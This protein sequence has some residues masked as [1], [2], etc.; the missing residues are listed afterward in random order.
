MHSNPLANEV[1]LTL[2]VACYNEEANIVATLETLL[3]ALEEVDFSWEIIVI[4]D[5]SRDR[6]V[7]RVQEFL[8][9]RPQQPI[10]LVVNESNR[11]LAQNYI[12][13]AFLGRGRYYR[14]VCGDNVEPQQTLV[15]V[16]KHLGEADMVIFY[17]VEC[18]GRT[19]FRRIL[20]RAYSRIINFLSG[21]RIKYY[22]GLALHLRYN[23]MR[24]HTNYRGFGFQADMIT[25]LL[26]EGFSYIEVPVKATERSAG[27]STALKLRNVLS[28]L[29]TLLDISI[30]RVGRLLYGVKTPS[31]A[32]LPPAP[33]HAAAPLQ[34]A[35]P[36]PPPEVMPPAPPSAPW[37]FGE[38]RTAP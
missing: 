9:V 31:R 28:V 4:D 14:L 29:H 30:R 24:W 18:P 15:E 16:F 26:D 7:Q 19:L 38:A 12:E 13:G 17:H 10:R 11:G 36:S 5:A 20:S 23:V 3:A 6:S 27:A 21:Y 37:V 2:F 1:D 8:E 22:N 35:S 33:A 32:H 25:R 34:T